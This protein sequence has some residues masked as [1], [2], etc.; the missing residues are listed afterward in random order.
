M[1]NS[2]FIISIIVLSITIMICMIRAF[3][4]PTKLDRLVVIN[5]IG[6]KTIVLISI[7]SF[8]LRETYFIDVV[9]VYALIS[10]VATTVIAG[11]WR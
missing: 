4:G 2:I 1:T 5:V 11:D 3:I 9:L 6:T 8:I 7:I 10:F